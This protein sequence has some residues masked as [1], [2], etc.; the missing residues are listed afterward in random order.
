MSVDNVDASTAVEPTENSK[1]LKDT[2]VSGEAGND[3]E[4]DEFDALDDAEMLG[5]MARS[6]YN[7]AMKRLF[8][9]M[10]GSGALGGALI[11]LGTIDVG[12][13]GFEIAN[14]LLL[15]I[16]GLP[17]S[18]LPVQTL[19]M[20]VGLSLAGAGL[21]IGQYFIDQPAQ[22]LDSFFKGVRFSGLSAEEEADYELE[23]DIGS[24]ESAE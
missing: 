20:A 21:Y 4:S 15:S 13:S 10:P 17:P 5:A 24:E 8:L 23:E 12:K 11:G 16:S 6:S 22:I 1:A 9:K 3:D 7:D 2:G 19:R 14:S 18:E